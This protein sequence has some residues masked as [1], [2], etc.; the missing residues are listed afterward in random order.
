M[1]KVVK[2]VFARKIGELSL[3]DKYVE[4]LKAWDKTSEDN[5]T[6]EAIIC[7]IKELS[8][9]EW[10]HLENNLFESRDWLADKGG[11]DKDLQ[12]RKCIL[13]VQDQDKKALLIDP[14]GYSYA[15]YVAV[16]DYDSIF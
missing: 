9:E 2:A 11:V 7:E 16:V 3:Y 13:A 14:Q 1:R 5:L 4:D 10:Q 6:Q 8:R 15:R 12:A